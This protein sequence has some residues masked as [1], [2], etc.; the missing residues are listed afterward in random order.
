VYESHIAQTSRP[1][2][3]STVFNFYFH[4][5]KALQAEGRGGGEI[6]VKEEIN[7]FYLILLLFKKPSIPQIYDYASLNGLTFIIF[8]ELLHKL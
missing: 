4:R 1:L 2:T 8:T 6:T 5:K 7:F 3:V